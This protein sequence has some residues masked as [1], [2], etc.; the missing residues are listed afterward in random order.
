MLDSAFIETPCEICLSDDLNLFGYLR[1]LLE[2]GEDPRSR[3]EQIWAR[4]GQTVAVLVLDSSGFSRISQSHG[5]VHYLAKLV[6]MRDIVNPG[7]E[8]EGARRSHFEADNVFAL[9]DHPDAAI[10]AARQCHAAIAQAR[11]MLTETEPFQVCVG[12]GYGQMLYSETLEGYFS[13]EMNIASKLGEDTAD[14]GET[15]LT[16][17]AHAARTRRSSRGRND[18]N[19]R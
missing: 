11:L 18:V 4:Y 9:F 1:N 19:S 16:E 14:G 10:R 7:F 8:A 17:S 15:L 6:Q 13:S 12:I 3:E 5:I 2:A